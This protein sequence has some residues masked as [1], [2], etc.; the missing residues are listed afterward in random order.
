MTVKVYKFV[1]GSEVIARE[2]SSQDIEITLSKPRVI[3]I[4]PH[5]SGRM[6]V[7]LIP[8]MIAAPESDI[9]IKSNHIMASNEVSV[10]IEKMYL[11]Q[12]SGIDLSPL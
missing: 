8:W 7:G 5:E 3:Q 6:G 4:M 9:T 10:D 11:Q 1:D 12:T 2:V